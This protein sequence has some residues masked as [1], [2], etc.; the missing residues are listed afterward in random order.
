MTYLKTLIYIQDTGVLVC[1]C[2]WQASLDIPTGFTVHFGS[3]GSVCQCG[4]SGS[5][6]MATEEHCREVKVEE[7]WLGRSVGIIFLAGGCGI[8]SSESSM[9]SGLDVSPG[10]ST[11]P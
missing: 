8:T 1:E 6:V 7:E 5:G 3:L 4:V 11:C 10:R 2:G 9:G